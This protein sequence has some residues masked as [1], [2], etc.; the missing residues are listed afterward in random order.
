M[1]DYSSQR[2]SEQNDVEK[3]I[4]SSFDVTEHEL[5][6]EELL[7]AEQR[8]RAIL[9][10]VQAGVVVVDEKTHEIIYV[11]PAAAKMAG[12]KE[13]NMI[14]HICHQFICPTQI[15]ECPISDLGKTV[16]NSEKILIKYNGE[17]LDILK[18]VAKVELAGRKCLMET[19][20]DITDRKEAE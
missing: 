19:F 8:T 3:M 1:K 2:T 15:G 11:N 6:K 17:K 4:K 5:N 10:H 12:M 18:T 16:D 9:N 20:V 14:G 7:N 13:K